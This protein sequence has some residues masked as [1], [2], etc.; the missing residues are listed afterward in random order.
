MKDGIAIK[1]D[2]PLNLDKIIVGS[3]VGVM[4]HSNGSLH[5]FLDGVHQGIACTNVP[6][7]VYPVIDIY[8]RCTQ[9]SIL[10]PPEIKCNDGDS[11]TNCRS[12]NDA[13]LVAQTENDI[14][15]QK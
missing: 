6:A 5:Y 2:Y 7:N 14:K 4:R 12:R 3:V 9:V 8:G 10:S 11:D 15:G 1:Y 13:T